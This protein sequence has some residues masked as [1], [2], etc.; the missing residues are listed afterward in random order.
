MRKYRVKDYFA[1][2]EKDN[3]EKGCYGKTLTYHGPRSEIYEADTLTSLIAKLKD[4]FGVD[5]VDLDSC[6]E[7]GRLDLSGIE[8]QAFSQS[9]PSKYTIE[10]WTKGE[11][12]LYCTTY[13]FTVEIV[14][15]KISLYDIMKA[16]NAK[17]V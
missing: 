1:Y 7:T 12:D 6:D 15:S 3:Y 8:R 9:R 17:I 16:E 13:I 4:V 10:K 5:G 2:S 14:E 11:I